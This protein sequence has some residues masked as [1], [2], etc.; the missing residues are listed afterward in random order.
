MREKSSRLFTSRNNRLL[1]RWAR[2]S[3]TRAVCGMAACCKGLFERSEHQR[4][5]RA[6]FVADVGEK[7]GLGAVDFSQ[8][9]CALPLLLEGTHVDQRRGDV[10]GRPLDKGAVVR[11]EIA[12]RNSPATRKPE[13]LR[14]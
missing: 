8:R 2:L 7:C 13:T 10:T 9:L 1:L 5:G 11:V 4:E 3:W 12:P 6:E 14:S